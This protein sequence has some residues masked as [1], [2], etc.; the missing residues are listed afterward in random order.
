[1]KSA[2]FASLVVLGA[3]GCD[4]ATPSD[5]LSASVDRVTAITVSSQ[6]FG[7]APPACASRSRRYNFALH[8]LTLT[9]CAATRTVTARAA[10]STELRNALRS[11]T[12]RSTACDG[13]DG[14]NTSVAFEYGAGTQPTGYGLGAAS[15]S[16]GPSA[17]RAFDT[18]DPASWAPAQAILDRV[19]NGS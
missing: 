14:T 17:M 11:V 16:S 2:L 3:L 10:D 13:F 4:P 1:M 9:E 18:I 12:I 7:V 15:C 8:T 19:A 6:S 5:V